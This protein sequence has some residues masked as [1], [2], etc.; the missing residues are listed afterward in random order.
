MILKY[1]HGQR[2]KY[3]PVLIIDRDGYRVIDSDITVFLILGLS[4]NGNAL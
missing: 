4:D 3:S 2:I 1:S